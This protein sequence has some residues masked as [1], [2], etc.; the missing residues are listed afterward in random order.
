MA[1]T[2]AAD[3][4]QLAGA[5][6]VFWYLRGHL[7]EGQQ[8]LEWALAHTAETSTGLRSR[9]LTG[10]GYMVWSQ[11]GSTSTQP[12]WRR[13]ALPSPNKTGDKDLAARGLHMLGLVGEFQ[14]QW[15][16]AGPYME[17]GLSAS[18]A[19]STW[20]LRWPWC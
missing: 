16:Q 12:N 6:V 20:R 4:L 2:E 5:L 7:R 10:L 17:Q 13:R 19:S 8:W 15:D 3:V 1:D 14:C 11:G 18:G 9:A